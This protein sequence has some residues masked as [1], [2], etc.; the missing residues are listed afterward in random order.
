M[1]EARETRVG[2]CVESF[3]MLAAHEGN[4]LWPRLCPWNQGRSLH[5]G[6]IGRDT[7]VGVMSFY[8][9]PEA[10]ARRHRQRGLWQ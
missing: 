5:A 10:L 3:M 7:D 6:G 8:M 2:L 4:D 9:R 1:A